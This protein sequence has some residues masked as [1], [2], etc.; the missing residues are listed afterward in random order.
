WIRFKDL[1]NEKENF[2]PYS[3]EAGNLI[4]DVRNMG[5][6]DAIGILEKSGLKVMISGRGRVV[7]QVPSQG[8]V[9]A[10]GD[11]IYLTLK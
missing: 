5:A 1:T 4:P 9:F 2:A 6:S 8:T 11:S 7:Q 3:P 10:K